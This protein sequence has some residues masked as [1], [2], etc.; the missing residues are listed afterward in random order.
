MAYSVL[1]LGIMF[2]QLYTLYQWIFAPVEISF[3]VNK[4]LYTG[5]RVFAVFGLQVFTGVFCLFIT[6]DVLNVS[7]ATKGNFINAVTTIGGGGVVK[8]AFISIFI[9]A[10]VYCIIAI[11]WLIVETAFEFCIKEFKL[12]KRKNQSKDPDEISTVV[13]VPSDDAA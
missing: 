6:Y 13:I 7:N 2:S 12:F 3:G 5:F 1:A 4:G 11:I 10:I 9:S 8:N